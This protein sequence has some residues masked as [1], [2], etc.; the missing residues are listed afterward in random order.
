MFTSHIPSFTRKKF[1]QRNFF[2]KFAVRNLKSK[3]RMKPFV[4]STLLIVFFLSSS[5]QENA[6]Y[7]NSF[8]STGFA[9][10]KEAA[11]FGLVFSGPVIN[12]GM[13]WNRINEHRMITYGYE[14]GV[15]IPFSKSIPA[16]DIYLKP[17]DIAYMFHIPGFYDRFYI[18]PDLKFEY[19]YTFYPQLQSGFDYWFTNFSLGLKAHYAFNYQHSAFQIILN[20]SLA[21]LTSRQPDYRD[22]YFFDIGFK[23]AVRDLHQNLGFG[24]LD[25]YNT[26]EFGIMWKPAPESRLTVGYEFRYSGYYPAPE[27][28]KVSHNI[29]IVISAKSK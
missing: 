26:T 15:G 23:Y 24:S 11:N 17:V 4:I 6:V 8:F 21:G 16:L 20:T 13:T 29:K 3:S 7:R 9:Q 19:N 10:V 14:L 12:Y 22:P 18:G 2:F 27:F 25:K 5:A 28:K 1:Q